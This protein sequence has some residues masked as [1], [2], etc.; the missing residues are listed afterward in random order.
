MILFGIT[1][2]FSVIQADAVCYKTRRNQKGD[3]ALA[4]SPF[5]VKWQK[6]D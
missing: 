3:R 2:L 6:D 5:L 4:R 1:A